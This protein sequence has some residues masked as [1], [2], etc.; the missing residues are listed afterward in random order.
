MPMVV[1]T[2]H[3][4]PIVSDP[5]I[6]SVILVLEPAWQFDTRVPTAMLYN[7]SERAVW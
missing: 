7:A 5:P 6:V 4:S 3:V 1:S 2:L